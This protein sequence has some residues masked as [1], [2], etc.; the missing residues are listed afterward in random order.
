MCTS[1]VGRIG[2]P[3]P[4][5]DQDGLP[6]RPTT[7][8][9][10]VIQMGDPIALPPQCLSRASAAMFARIILAL[11]AAIA[12]LPGAF[13]QAVELQVYP[14]SIRLDGP[15]AQQRLVVLARQNGGIHDLSREASATVEDAKVAVVRKGIVVPVGDGKTTLNISAGGATKTIPIT[16]AKTKAETPVSFTGEIEPILSKAGCNS[17]A[18]HGAQLGRGGFKLSL[19]GFDPE[20]DHAQIVQSNEG[21]RVVPSDPERSILLLKPSLTM[22]HG[23]GERFKPHGREYEMIRRW[24]EDGAPE[25]EKNPP[26]VTRIEVF[27]ASRVI[28]PGESQQLVVTAFWSNG[29]TEDVTPIAQYDALNEA[30][31]A[32][33]RDGLVSAKVKGEAH[34]MIR[35]S[36][37]AAVARFTLPFA[38]LDKYPVLSRNN[39]ID[40]KLIARWKE[41]GITPSTLA[42]DGEFLRRLYLDAIGTLPTPEEIRAFLS[43]KS[44]D[45]RK[46]LIDKVL[47]R[48]EFIDFWTLKWGDLL[49][50]NR[51]ALN[52]KG[53]W[54]FHNWVCAEL[55]DGKPVDEF[56]RDIITAEGST[57]TEGPANF[58]RVGRNADDWAETTSQVF[59]GV[60]VQCAK[61]HHHPF[62]K[63]TQDDYYG[64]AAFFTRLGTKNSKEFGLFGQESVIY[65]RNAGEATNP[66]TRKVVKPHPFDGPVMDDEFDRRAKLADWLT[67][68]TNPFFGAISSIAFGA[69]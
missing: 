53:M 50:I 11:V 47:D 19:F 38:K 40:D 52:D 64:L 28:A 35:F 51:D 17:G 4:G 55:R 62:E 12:F 48:P 30:V 13:G 54:S 59:L 9:H 27:P 46:K 63:W 22:E 15:R 49:R 69:T 60:R 61:C 67:A 24:L 41:L 29:R 16:V 42:S 32:V 36:G 39:F 20:F 23:G 43:D 10:A 45:K 56:V 3:S 7:E 18:C 44:P 5:A 57:F 21:R 34:V 26:I 65:L 58:Y 2:N 66:R 6:I 1:A 14:D 8:A 25:A 33:D 37:Q 31:A 68:K